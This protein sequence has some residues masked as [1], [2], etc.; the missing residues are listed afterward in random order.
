MIVK[1]SNKD[2]FKD[3]PWLETIDGLKQCTSKQIKYVALCY[4]YQSPF[5]NMSFEN[6]REEALSAAGYK[7]DAPDTKKV[8]KQTNKKLER[9]IE[10]YSNMQR[11]FELDLLRS[12]DSQLMQFVELFNKKDK[13][14]RQYSNALRIMKEL[15]ALVKQRKEIIDSLNLR[16][17][18]E[19]FSFGKELDDDGTSSKQLSALDEFITES[20]K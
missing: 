7:K 16:G 19:K 5:K 9:A 2:V 18:D 12:Y 13:D 17:V 8:Y 4:D 1:V 6:R 14:T 3:N 15:P 11:D 10:I 20:I